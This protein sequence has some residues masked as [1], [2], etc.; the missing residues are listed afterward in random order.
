MRFSTLITAVA[1]LFAT[2]GAPAH[3]GL[4]GDGTN[5]VSVNFWF[6]SSST[7]AQ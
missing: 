1:A 3:A 6:P 5:T 2:A 7:S 4:I